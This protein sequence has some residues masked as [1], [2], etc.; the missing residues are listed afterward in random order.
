M[1]FT[2]V[3]DRELIFLISTFGSFAGLVDGF[4][5]CASTI[6]KAAVFRCVVLTSARTAPRHSKDHSTRPGSPWG[7]RVFALQVERP[8]RATRQIVATE[9]TT[10]PQSIRPQ[11]FNVIL[12][13]VSFFQFPYDLEC[14]KQIV[15]IHTRMLLMS[16]A[17]RH[18]SRAPRH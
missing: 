1:I 13:S 12:A 8:T 6:P 7:A 5:P 3:C 10:S 15:R 18:F 17:A 16:R 4:S 2:I 9:F 14:Q 11:A